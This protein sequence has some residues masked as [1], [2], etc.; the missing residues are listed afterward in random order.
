MFVVSPYPIFLDSVMSRIHVYIVSV[1]AP[2]F[3]QHRFQVILIPSML[4]ILVFYTENL[5]NQDILHSIKLELE[6]EELYAKNIG[7]LFVEA[8]I[9]L[10]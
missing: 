10:T 8:K 2:V 3:V 9:L 7:I 4:K 5:K 6:L 1:P